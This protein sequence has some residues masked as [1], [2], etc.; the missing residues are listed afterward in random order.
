MGLDPAIDLGRYGVWLR[1]AQQTPELAARLQELGYGTVW[2]GGSPGGGLAVAEGLL[3]ATTSLVVATGIVNIWKDGPEVVANSYH[4][5]EQAHPGRFVLGVGVGHPEATS[6]YRKPYDALVDYLDG[7]DE[8]G[9]PIGRRVIAA[10]GPQ[11]LRLAGAR[12]A[13]THPYLVTPEHSRRAREILGTDGLVAPEQHV[14]LDADAERARAAG[15]KALG[16]Y[17]GLTNYVTNWKRLGFSDQDVTAP[18]SDAL[19]DGLI[20]HGDAAAVRARL[21]EHLSLGADHVA[22]QLIGPESGFA[23]I[24]DALF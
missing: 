9:V 7:L 15:R 17:L 13:G 4:R 19:V 24:A 8:G 21:D 1:G 5:L 14:V 22:L 2:L 11:V 18:G 3:E 23:T 12:S 16:T 6:Q 10:L 20:A